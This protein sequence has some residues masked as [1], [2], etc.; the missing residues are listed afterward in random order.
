MFYSADSADSLD[1]A[2]GVGYYASGAT[3]RVSRELAAE[4]L[5]LAVL[6]GLD[7]AAAYLTT[8]WCCCVVR[9]VASGAPEQVCSAD[10]CRGVSASD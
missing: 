3:L 8:V 2:D 6:H 5:V 1:E 9:V 7:V 10:C 4:V